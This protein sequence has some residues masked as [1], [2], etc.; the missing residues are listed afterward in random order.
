MNPHYAF[1]HAFPSHVQRL[2]GSF[3]ASLDSLIARMEPNTPELG[4]VYLR[5][6]L[7]LDERLGIPAPE[8]ELQGGE[9][10]TTPGIDVEKMVRVLRL[11]REHGSIDPRYSE[12]LIQNAADG[13]QSL[14]NG[15]E[16]ASLPLEV[17]EAMAHGYA[18]L[19]AEAHKLRLQGLGPSQEHDLVAATLPEL[20][21]G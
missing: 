16:H 17:F 18:S 10:Y 20:P 3:N 2:A 7:P 1:D 19:A 14:A 21:N 13:L 6:L 12:D 8:E 4:E 5:I 11:L 15:E 9:N